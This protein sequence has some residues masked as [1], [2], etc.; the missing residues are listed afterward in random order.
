MLVRVEI[1]AQGH[2]RQLQLSRSSGSTR[3]DEAALAAVRV[4]RFKPYA[5]NGSPLVVWTTVPIVFELES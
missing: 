5:E 4:A 1:D 3:L 2:A